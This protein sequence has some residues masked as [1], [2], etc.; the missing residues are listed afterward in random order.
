MNTE[1]PIFKEV[2]SF[3]QRLDDY[4]IEVRP[5]LASQKQM[6]I[7]DKLSVSIAA[8]RATTDQYKFVEKGQ[9][10]VNTHEAA[11]PSNDYERKGVSE[12]LQMLTPEQVDKYWEERY[13]AAAQLRLCIAQAKA[14]GMVHPGPAVL[15]QLRQCRKNNEELNKQLVT[16]TAL[17]DVTKKNYDGLRKLMPKPSK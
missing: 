17:Y 6:I 5:K 3:I 10:F 11:Q 1:P 2:E 16:L 8:F 9:Q 13:A 4:E 12:A 14:H 15:K 7:A